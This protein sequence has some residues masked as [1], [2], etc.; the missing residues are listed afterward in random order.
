[1]LISSVQLVEAMATED[2]DRKGLD[3]VT[4]IHF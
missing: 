3:P 1:M 4:R 2:L